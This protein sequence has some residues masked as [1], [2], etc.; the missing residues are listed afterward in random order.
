MFIFKKKLINRD[1]T[2]TTIRLLVRWY[3][4][5]LVFDEAISYL[6]VL[7]VRMVLRK[8]EFF[9]RGFLMYILMI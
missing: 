5:Q 6:M 2:N 3:G 4:S 8:E 1:I 7:Q 9:L